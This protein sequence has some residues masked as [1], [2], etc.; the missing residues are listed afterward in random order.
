MKNVK[1]T[2]TIAAICT[3][4]AAVSLT[5]VGFATWLIIG[6]T[7]DK[8]TGNVSIQVADIEDDE[9]LITEASVTDGTI[10]FG[11]AVGDTTGPITANGADTE[12]LSI[13]FTFTVTCPTASVFGNV[14]AKMELDGTS[15]ANTAF[16]TAISS[17][18]INA[19]DI[20]STTDVAVAFL[21]PTAEADG[22]YKFTVNRS[23]TW[24]SEFGGQ[25]PSV[26]ANDSNLSQVRSALET[27]HE[28]SGASLKITLS[29]HTK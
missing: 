24:G 5:G 3:S 29:S 20:Y 21:L 23:F 9:V 2:K 19:P 27:L 16:E 13:T 7:N 25:N 22:S 18:Y 4:L 15:P 12:D 11:P 28:A 17:N 1:R 10:C 14:T 6:T 26:Y 8:P